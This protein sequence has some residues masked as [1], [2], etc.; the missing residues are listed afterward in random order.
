MNQ[1]TVQPNINEHEIRHDWTFEEALA[2]YNLP[3]NDLLE[4]AHE[5]HKKFFNSN[6]I[7]ISTLYNIKQAGCPE[8]CK[9]CNQSAH[10]NKKI[11][12]T[13]FVSVEQTIEA[14]KKAKANGATRFCMVAAWRG[15]H[16]KDIPTLVEMVKEVKALGMETC[17]SAGFLKAHQAHQLKEAGLEYYNHNIETS[18]EHYPNIC[19]THKFSDRLETV[20]NVTDAGMR[21]CCGLLIG[22]DE[23]VEDRARALRVLAN[24]KEHPKSVPI[25]RLIK[26]PETP[27]AEMEG[28]D[29]FDLVR[30][31]ALARIMIPTAYVRLSGGR[32][33]TSA[34]AQAL[35]YF[36]GANS[37]HFGDTLLTSPNYSP[38][39][40][41]E[42]FAKLGL[43]T[44]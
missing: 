4:K 3:F 13:P 27:G 44:V 17:V 19:S 41:M 23:S 16:D 15:P 11:P 26:F 36:A 22:M 28:A 37:I 14:A 18:Q 31:V 30:T 1:K 40:D 38:E 32:R 9:F 25:N 21:V 42:T 33:E 20:Q 7:K 34:T 8:D 2:I 12:K 10:Y 39:K 29:D 5:V 24:L 43:T 6:E 35:C